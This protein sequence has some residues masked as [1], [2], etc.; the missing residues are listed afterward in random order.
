MNSLRCFPRCSGVSHMEHTFC[1]NFVEGTIENVNKTV[2]PME[3]LRI[4]ARFIEKS[5][6]FMS[7]ENTLEK[8]P[9]VTKCFEGIIL[10]SSSHSTFHFLF[11]S[12]VIALFKSLLCSS[13]LRFGGITENIFDSPICKI[14]PVSK[15]K[16]T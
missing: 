3:K 13:F 14:L 6:K 12:N 7:S 1:G 15:T 4:Y 9:D 8:I 16:I 2:F 10:P 11:A 5:G